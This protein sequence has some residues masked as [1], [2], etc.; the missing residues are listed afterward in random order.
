MRVIIKKGHE[1]YIRG[2]RYKVL[3]TNIYGGKY[4][5]IVQET[6]TGRISAMDREVAVA[7]KEVENARIERGLPATPMRRRRRKVKTESRE[8]GPLLLTVDSTV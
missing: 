2:K 4:R 3:D 8:S 6:S 5:Y 7:A 1:L